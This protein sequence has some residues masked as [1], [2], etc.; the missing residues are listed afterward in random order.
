MAAGF[1][2]LAMLLA[3]PARFPSDLRR[4]EPPMNAL[5]GFF[6]D[7][8]RIL[9]NQEARYGLLGLGFFLALLT[10]GAGVMAQFALDPGVATDKDRQ[11]W[12]L[13]YVFLG[14]ALGSAFAGI[15]KHIYRALSQ[16]PVAALGMI[17]ALGWAAWTGKLEAPCIL[18]GFMGGLLNVPLRAFYQA[19]VPPDARGNGMACM[20]VSI[21]V[22]TIALSLILFLLAEVGLLQ[23]VI[24]QM[25]LLMVLAAVGLVA[26]TCFAF[27]GVLEQGLEIIEWPMYRVSAAG[28][29]L[30]EFPMHGPVIVIANHTAWMDPIWIG[31]VVPRFVTPMMTSVYYDKPVIR[32]LMVHVAHT[33][34]VPQATFRRDAPELKD[35]VAALD[36]RRL[37]LVFPE[38]AL[39]RKEEQFIRYFG[40]GIW[41][42]LKERPRTP[43]I[44]CWVEGGFGSYTSY[45]KGPPTVNKRLDRRR[46]IRI[47]VAAPTF[48]D[49]NVLADQR[50]ARIFLMR[51]CLD[52]RKYLGLPPGELPPRAEE[53]EDKAD[54]ENA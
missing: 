17:V 46:P 29:G 33:I 9:G 1:N 24:G 22:G 40:Q 49:P 12:S 7:L 52:A 39:K 32:W 43:V 42:I 16:V 25:I 31:T 26:A 10:V 54:D 3:V 11:L 23:S 28:P 44:A 35:A 2:V 14:V 48:V 8:Q 20:N 15:Q 4:P 53:Q 45:F 13:F 34:R 27:R 6:A 30:G 50:A 51:A 37:L 18:L 38:G 47:G 41:R 19:R 5:R 21:Y 36:A